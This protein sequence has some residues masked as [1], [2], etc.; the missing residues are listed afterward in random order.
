[1]EYIIYILIAIISILIFF[2]INLLKQTE[3]L[4]D[5]INRNTNQLISK[6]NL[7]LLNLRDIDS[8]GA[9]EKDDEV[10]STFNDII[11]AIQD[12]QNSL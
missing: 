12:L 4:D 2:I 9:F 6:M 10:G 11:N 1:M 3:Q 5:T 8:T 7:T